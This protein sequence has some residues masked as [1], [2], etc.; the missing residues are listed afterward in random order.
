MAFISVPKFWVPYLM[1][2]TGQS[3]DAPPAVADNMTL[4]A[5]EEEAQWIGRVVL[6]AGTG[7]KTFG[8]SGSGIRWL[9]GASIAFDTAGGADPTLRVGVKKS[10]TI[11][12]TTGPPARATIGAAAFDVYDDLV[13]GTDTITS[14]TART[15]NMS[16]GTPFTVTHGDLLA[17]CFH[18]NATVIGSTLVKMRGTTGS[19]AFPAGVLVKSGPTYNAQSVIPNAM[20]VFDDASFGWLDGSIITSAGPTTEAIGNT[21]IYGNVFR[22]PYRCKVDAISCHIITGGTT[23]LTVGLWSTPAGT[24]TLMT[25]GSLSLDPHIFSVSSIRTHTHLLPELVTL[26][27]NTDY[28]VGCL[29]NSATSITIEHFS[30]ENVADMLPTGFDSTCYAAKSTA[31]AA[32]AAQG[33]AQGRRRAAFSVR[34]AEIETTAAG[35]GSRMI[36]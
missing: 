34:V 14:T 4:D 17:I 20:L 29:Q 36:G 26:E 24:P 10:T 32:V 8:T 33:A 9:P 19:L 12:A 23:N 28:L 25:N 21:N 15:D 5:D 7:S 13:G 31:G 11:D 35:G 18:L 27:A 30:V 2:G 3:V 22:V 6:Q 1:W 16:A